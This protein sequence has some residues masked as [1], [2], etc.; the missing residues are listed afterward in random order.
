MSKNYAEWDTDA[1]KKKMH[2]KQNKTNKLF[3]KYTVVGSAAQYLFILTVNVF[4]CKQGIH[5]FYISFLAPVKHWL[6][7]I[8]MKWNQITDILR[9][10]QKGFNTG[11]F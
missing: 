11:S 1:W 6:I 2:E 9:I 7:S 8:T 4:S 10:Q 3:E 5:L